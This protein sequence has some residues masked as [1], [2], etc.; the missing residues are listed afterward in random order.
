MALAQWERRIIGQ[1]TKLAL[2][3]V[4]HRGEV[5][6]GRPTTVTRDAVAIITAMRA[7]GGQP[8]VVDEVTLVQAHDYGRRLSGI[9]ASATGTAGLAGLLADPPTAGC[10]AVI[11]SGVER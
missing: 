7:T 4:K 8:L 3:Q 6:L 9:R 11:F 10:A 2:G 5:K 1:R